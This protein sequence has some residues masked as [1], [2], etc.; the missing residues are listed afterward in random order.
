MVD[1]RMTVGQ[2]L[3]RQ[4]E[5]Q[6]ISLE[7]VSKDT[8]IKPAFL[9]ALEGDDFEQLPAEAYA[10]GFIRCYSKYIGLNPEETLELYRHQ[11]EPSK[12]QVQ[13]QVVKP[14]HLKSIKNHF[15]DFLTTMVGGTA[16]YSASKSILRPKD[17]M[18]F[19]RSI[20]LPLPSTRISPE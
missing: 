7:S 18:I 17:W 8:R 19:L 12:I 3:Q 5:T 16:A 1:Q 2:N 11:V 15:L 9:Q 13:E 6:K 20:P 4:R 14:S 10:L